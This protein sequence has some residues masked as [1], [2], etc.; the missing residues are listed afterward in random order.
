MGDRLPTMASI[1]L[2]YL[3]AISNSAD[4]E[5]SFSLY[6][7]IVTNRRKSLSQKSIKALVFLYYNQHVLNCVVDATLIPSVPELPNIE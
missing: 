3:N 1:A 4:A 6:N 7:M 2:R 5:R